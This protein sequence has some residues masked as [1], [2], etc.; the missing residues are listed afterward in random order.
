[1]TFPS[2]PRLPRTQLT[3]TSSW[4]T[5]AAWACAPRGARSTGGATAPRGGGGFGPGERGAENGR[6]RRILRLTGE[7]RSAAGAAAAGILRREPLESPLFALAV[8][9]A[10]VSGLDDALGVLRARM[11][12]AA[13]RLTDEERALRAEAAGPWEQAARERRIAHL[14]ADITWIQ[15]VLG[16]RVAGPVGDRITRRA[17]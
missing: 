15:G 8:A 17:G 1:M 9:A 12:T 3:R 7:G 10:G 16:R 11:A 13:R 2:S 4:T 5:C 6:F 14:R